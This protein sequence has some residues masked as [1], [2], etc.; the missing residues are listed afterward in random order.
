MPCAEFTSAQLTSHRASRYGARLARL[1]AVGASSRGTALCV[2]VRDIMPVS[3]AR[4]SSSEALACYFALRLVA[5]RRRVAALA[6]AASSEDALTL[7]P[8]DSATAA[9]RS[10]ALGGGANF[11]KRGSAPRSARL[12]RAK[13]AA[14]RRTRTKSGAVTDLVQGGEGCPLRKRPEPAPLRG[15]AV[16][17][18][19]SRSVRREL[20]K[21][22]PLADRARWS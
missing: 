15:G 14:Q 12:S 4:A 11:P 9:A 13:F 7:L 17:R 3:R 2:A 16:T 21:R 18:G 8:N 19:A 22:T 10:A 6:P 20:P 5:P 1:R